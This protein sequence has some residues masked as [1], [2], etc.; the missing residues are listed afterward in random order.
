MSAQRLG[1]L[2]PAGT[3][4]EEAA[5]AY[6]PR[7]ERVMYP[8]ISQV[9]QAVDDGAVSQAI[10][11][12]ENSLQGAVPE[13]LDFL[14]RTSRTRIVQEL[15]LRIR[16]CLVVKRGTGRDAV[17][18]I[19]SHPQPLGQCRRY[20][21][22][23]FPNIEPVASLSTASAVSDM[24]GSEIPAAAIAPRRAAELYGAEVVDEDIQDN[25]N[26]FTRFVVL[27]PTD[28]P[29]TGKDKTSI[30]FAFDNDRPGLLYDV[31]GAF[32]RRGINLTKVESRPTGEKLGRYVFLIDFE[33]YRTDP[34][35]A[36]ALREVQGLTA[37]LKTFG[38][39]PATIYSTPPER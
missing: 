13:V 33:G 23:N 38:S 32:A 15:A 14:I 36:D 19:Y 6:D 39:Y 8:T 27:A 9:T 29:R 34:N 12:I 7:L 18:R 20:L 3:Y 2:G 26:N 1:F 25:P 11:P 5:I 35:V 31:M 24:L 37:M 22:R 30:A 4:S 17:R 16:N 10:V 21:A 28:H